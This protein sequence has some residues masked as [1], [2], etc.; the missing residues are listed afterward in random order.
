M[1]NQRETLQSPGI[2]TA[3]AAMIFQ[4][5]P[6]VN[7]AKVYARVKVGIET[8]GTPLKWLYS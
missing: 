6:I 4:K 7:R 1:V 5:L 8:I 2:L 3:S